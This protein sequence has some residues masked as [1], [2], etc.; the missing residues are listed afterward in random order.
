MSKG[1]GV[2]QRAIVDVLE[3]GGR[4]PLGSLAWRVA[5]ELNVIGADGNLG[6]ENYTNTFRA[7]KGLVQRGVIARDVQGA[8]SL[9]ELVLWYPDRAQQAA[10]RN[11]RRKL[12]AHVEPYTT[13][14]RLTK[15]HGNATCEV[16]A[17]SLLEPRAHA[18]AVQAWVDLEDALVKALPKLVDEERGRVLDV[19]GRG[20]EL[21]GRTRRVTGKFELVAALRRLSQR[22]VGGPQVGQRIQAFEDLF[23]HRA[24]ERERLEALLFEV[25][26]LSKRNHPALRAAFKDHLLTV[27]RHFVTRLPGHVS[28]RTRSGSVVWWEDEPSR[29]TFSPLLDKLIMHDA[30]KDS[31]FFEIV[32][33]DEE[34]RSRLGPDARSR[35]LP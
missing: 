19:L 23:P 32:S 16:L 29:V 25:V 31:P 18:C 24:Y 20:R 1:L 17:L 7:A 15:R 11:L 26:D 21:M 14:H 10:V 3:R 6:A 33:G 13:N 5:E 22:S 2:I 12:L 28:A 35:M 27:E 9:A 4:L 30:L 8:Q 34:D